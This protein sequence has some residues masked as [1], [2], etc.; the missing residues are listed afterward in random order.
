MMNQTV[1]LSAYGMELLSSDRQIVDL[2]LVMDS[3]IAEA[4]ADGETA[5]TV[6][7]GTIWYPDYLTNRPMPVGIINQ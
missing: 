2:S 6:E 1:T 4:S 3:L 7:D 5:A